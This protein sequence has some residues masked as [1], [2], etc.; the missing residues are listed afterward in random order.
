MK[1]PVFLSLILIGFLLSCQPTTEENTA[2]DR[3]HRFMMEFVAA[4]S[5]NQ[6]RLFKQ[7]DNIKREIPEIEIRIVVHGPAIFM[8]QKG[9]KFREEILKKVG[10]GVV[11]A[12]CRNS[13]VAR[14]L[15]EDSI[16][17]E[18]SIVPSALVDIMLKQEEGWSYI[19]SDN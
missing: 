2:E 14:N 3:P 16:L 19:K 10:E 8:L 12:A 17:P 6:A 1:L 18:A 15:P 9:G 7:I 13:L 5:A 11:F 4:D